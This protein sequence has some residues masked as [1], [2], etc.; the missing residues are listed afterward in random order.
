VVRD[1]RSERACTFPPLK[2]E[3][4]GSVDI[5]PFDQELVEAK[6]ALG[7]IGPE[8]LP[9]LAWDALEADLDGPSVRKLAALVNPSGWET[10]RILPAFMAETG[11]KI[12]SRQEASVRL[13]RQVARRI[14]SEG[15]D[16]VVHTRDFELLWIE[17]GYS[18]SI[19]EVG[20]LDDEKHVAEYVGQTESE[21][22]EYARRALTNLLAT[23]GE[24][25]HP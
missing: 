21:F 3:T 13:A 18:T 4:W 8:E 24:D 22:R 10:D 5:M 1:Q 11:L 23:P 16:P 7:R 2:S 14:L 9:S 25:P 15:L 19:Q 17:S 20:T 6:I 12:I